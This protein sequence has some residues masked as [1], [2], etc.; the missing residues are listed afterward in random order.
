VYQTYTPRLGL[1]YRFYTQYHTITQYTQALEHSLE[2]VEHQA[3]V[4]TQK[5]NTSPQRVSLDA[6]L[7]TPQGHSVSLLVL[8]ETTLPRYIELITQI[9]EQS[10]DR[11][12][13]YVRQFQRLTEELSALAIVLHTLT[14]AT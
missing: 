2:L 10:D 11:Q 13:Y 4:T 1:A 9:Y 12:R 5:T 7:S 6:Y 14:T 3:Y 8:K